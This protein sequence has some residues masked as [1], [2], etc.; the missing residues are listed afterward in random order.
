LNYPGAVL[1]V[2]I[3]GRVQWRENSIIRIGEDV[4][5]TDWG[6]KT[7]THTCHILLISTD[8]AKQLF[9]E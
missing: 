4:A 1:I 8:C 3:L 2:W 5:T 6:T 9:H 7:H